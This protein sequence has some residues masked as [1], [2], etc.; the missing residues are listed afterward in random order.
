LAITSFLANQ[1]V[2]R[3]SPHLPFSRSEQYPLV[4]E[5]LRLVEG[6][7]APVNTGVRGLKDLRE[8]IRQDEVGN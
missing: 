6:R 2:C 8:Y 1:S 5:R 3:E 4:E 7:V